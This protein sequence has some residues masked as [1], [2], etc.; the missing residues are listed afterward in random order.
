SHGGGVAPLLAACPSC[1][2]AAACAE[3]FQGTIDGRDPT[4][5]NPDISCRRVQL[6]N[7]LEEPGCNECRDITASVRI[8]A[9]GRVLIDGHDQLCEPAKDVVQVADLAL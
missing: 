4:R 8:D 1:L 9:V 2:A 3:L 6:R 5:G 7:A